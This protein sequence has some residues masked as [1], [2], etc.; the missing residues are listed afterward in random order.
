MIAPE[1]RKY[2]GKMGNVAFGDFDQCRAIPGTGVN[3]GVRANH[4]L[5]AFARMTSKA[6]AGAVSH[7]LPGNSQACLDQNSVNNLFCTIAVQRVYRTA[8]ACEAATEELS[9]EA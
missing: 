3:G 7:F 4:S 5:P 2:P 6:M 9:M 1:D 8:P